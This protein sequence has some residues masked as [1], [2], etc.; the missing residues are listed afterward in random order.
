MVSPELRDRILSATGNAGYEPP[1]IAPSVPVFDVTALENYV[2]A[3]PS[4]WTGDKFLGGFGITKDYTVA[5]MWLLR[6][7]SRQLFTENLY[8]RGLI[9]RLVTNEI[10]K[11][12][13]L[14]ATP[15][16]DILGIEP[17]TLA[18]WAESVERRYSLYGKDKRV[19][20][21]R[22]LRTLA[23]I[24]QEGRI[25]A[26]VSGDVL[27]V[28][29]DRNG[30]PTVDL[31]DAEHVQTPQSDTQIRAA[32]NRG[33]EIDGGVE[34]DASGAHVAFY[35]T[36]K[37][38]TSRRV[39]AYGPRTGRLQ[40]W[41]Y[42]G[43]ERI[44][45]VRGQPILSLVMQ[46]LKELDRY[47]DAEQ[48]A[49]VINSMIAMWVEKTQDKPSSL[50]VQAGATRRDE[51]TTQN[52]SAGRKDVTFSQHMPGMMLQE[53]QHGE[54]P[55][56][57]DTRRPNVNYGVF[58][59]AILSAFAWA[60]EVPPE[61]LMLQFQN[62]YSASRGATNEFKIYLDRV[63]HGFGENFNAPI[64]TDFLISEVL[65]RKVVAPGFFEAWRNRDRDGWLVF[66][67]WISSDWA[68]AIKPN[69]DLLKEANAYRTLVMEG[70]IT[71]DRATRELTGMKYSKAVQQLA[72]ENMQLGEA[73]EPLIEVGVL[74]DENPDS[75]P[76]QAVGEE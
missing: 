47:R 18:A 72:T 50:P 36:Q 59:S 1:T 43:I 33:N 68:G 22:K 49:A 53:L 38:G 71:R 65:S 64:Y 46:S 29:R 56:S 44:D 74:K 67:A 63:R 23:G 54:K 24:Q 20:D 32:R 57:Y 21:Y 76:D 25:K 58:E 70:F 69:V 3:E 28:L 11:G 66:N 31:I 34:L 8:A 27:V 41:L 10:N 61:T 5:N 13:A 73:L 12:L 4:T 40:A 30:L 45:G 75:V 62:N 51:V 16:A 14:E 9:R 48:R 52:D 19:C 37:N 2:G 17:E 6:K 42:Y 55:Q 39:P 35:V 15:D 7:R 26:L 60:N